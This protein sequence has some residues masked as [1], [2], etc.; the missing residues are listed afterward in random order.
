MTKAMIMAAKYNVATVLES[1][2]EKSTIALIKK[3]GGET[4]ETT[5]CEA[6]PSGNKLA[7]TDI[8]KGED[9]IKY[10]VVIGY[11][12]CDI[13]KGALVHV[14]NVRSHRINIPDGIITEILKQMNLEGR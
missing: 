12:S 10:G 4:T 3:E 13:P 2:A 7:L 1:A 8:S 6:I 14:H 5:V 9:I 11:A